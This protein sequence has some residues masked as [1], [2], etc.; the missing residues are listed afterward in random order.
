[1]INT[2]E[3]NYIGCN[4]NAK[5]HNFPRQNS[6]GKRLRSTLEHIDS[7]FVL[8]LYD[9][10]ILEKM[11][12]S[13]SISDVLD[14]MLADKDSAVAYLI[15][16]GL[17]TYQEDGTTNFGRVKD[18]V[19]YR[20]NS[21]PG[22]WRR[23]VLLEYVGADD[24]PWAWEVFGTYRTY[25]DKKNY[26][27]LGS[28]ILDIYPYNYEKGGAIYRGK[29]VASVVQDKIRKYGLNIDTAIRGFSE[30]GKFEPRTLAW[31]ISFMLVGFKMLGFKS[32]RFV[33]RYI[34]EK[35]NVK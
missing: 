7:E 3:E 31:K 23:S 10:F 22:V 16:T 26:Y 33:I 20:L 4:Y 13:D 32:L 28:G 8:M 24:N 27:T 18:F 15:N 11:I 17:P 6:W 14:F 12:N 1:M 21:A 35:F 2:E 19:D 34:K 9:D 30:E 29:W 25:G 5:V